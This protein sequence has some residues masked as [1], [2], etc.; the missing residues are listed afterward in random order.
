MRAIVIGRPEFD[1]QHRPNMKPSLLLDHNDRTYSFFL[2]YHVN[3][4]IGI[5]YP[6]EYKRYNS[7]IEA[8]GNG[9][10]QCH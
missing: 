1:F 6:T 8:K 7:N 3:R 2:F 5:L 10:S 4:D 9:I